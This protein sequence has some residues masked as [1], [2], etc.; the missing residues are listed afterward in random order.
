MCRF[1]SCR[2]WFPGY[3][4][5]G[6]ALYTHDLYNHKKPSFVFPRLKDALK[7]RADAGHLTATVTMDL[8]PAE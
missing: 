8:R 5:T 3:R 7:E 4:N 6:L 2:T 1:F